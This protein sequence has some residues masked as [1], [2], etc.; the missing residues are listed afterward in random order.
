MGSVF[1]SLVS[2]QLINF[3]CFYFDLWPS[4]L[5]CLANMVIQYIGRIIFHE[6]EVNGHSLFTL[7]ASM[8]MLAFLLWGMHLIMTK[9][10]MIYVY[11]EILRQGSLSPASARKLA[12]KLSWG[13]T[14]VFQRS[15]RV[16]LV[17]IF[18]RAG[19]ST[20]RCLVTSASCRRPAP[21]AA[22]PLATT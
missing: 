15:A 3:M 21:S 6:E 2:Q 18:Q 1:W 11:A 13:A 9:V 5:S 10:G 20:P 17:P 19:G 14:V 12:G 7:I 4:M 8:V 22:S 16:F